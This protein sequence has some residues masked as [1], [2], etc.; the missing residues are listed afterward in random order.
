[1]PNARHE[2]ILQIIQSQEISTQEALRDILEAQGFSVT[3]ATISRDIRQLGLRKRRTASGISCYTKAHTA[4]SAPNNLLSDVVVKID[5]AINTVVVTCHAGSAQAACAV[6]DRMQLPEIVGTIA[7]DDT[8]F[9]LTRSEA[10]AK[11]LIGSLE[12]QIW[13]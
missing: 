1:M 6:L 4:P 3:Q 8:I 9:I 11:Q 2:A 12:S 7:G 13:G 10:S 5:Y